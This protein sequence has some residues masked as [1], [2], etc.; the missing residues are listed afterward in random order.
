M[1]CALIIIILKKGITGKFL[2]YKRNYKNNQL[3][4]PISPQLIIFQYYFPYSIPIMQCQ[5]LSEVYNIHTVYSSIVVLV[6]LSCCWLSGCY[7]Q[8][9]VPG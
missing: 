5:C 2:K 8:K 1:C 9:S 7:D 3:Q 4:H 6:I